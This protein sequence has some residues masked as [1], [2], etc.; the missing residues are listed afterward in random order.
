MGHIYKVKYYLIIKN[1]FMKVIGK[2]MV[3]ERKIS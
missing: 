2:C 3:I 1:E